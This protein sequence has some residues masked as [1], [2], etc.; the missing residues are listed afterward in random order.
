MNNEVSKQW[1]RREGY[2]GPESFPEDELAAYAVGRTDAL[3]GREHSLYL[4]DG[5]VLHY[6]FT[7][8]ETLTAE[9]VKGGHGFEARDCQYTATESA[10]GIF[11]LK[12]GYDTNERL[13]T[14]V[15]LD[16]NRNQAVVIDGEIPAE[17]DD[18]YRLR[19]THVGGC[20]GEPPAAGEI[21]APSFPPDLVGKRFVADYSE[22]YAWELIYMNETR[23][24]WQGLKGNPGIGDTE[25]YDASSFAPGVYTVSWSEE[26]ETLAAVFL[27]NF[28]ART[29][30]GHMW[31]YAPELK[32]FL[33]A[34]LGGRIVDPSEFG[35]RHTLPGDTDT[36]KAVKQKNVDVVLRAHNEVWNQGNYDLINEIYAEDY[37]CHFI[38]GLEAAGQ[39][40]VREFISAHRKSFP[41]WTE[42]V[43]DIIA[44][45]DRVVTRYISTGTHEGEFQ[46][47]AATGRKITISEVSI[48]RVLNGKIVE[49][50]GFPDGL[51]HIRQLTDD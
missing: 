15:I 33:H 47:I 7:D 45:G 10:P 19:K 36:A 31:G 26:A 21:P 41:D 22:R 28:D 42:K 20:I 50:W 30:T 34:P 43:V 23:V 12:H 51:S 2:G 49:Q 48:H 8:G 32:K 40:G 13:T 17:G 1:K 9:G 37:Q 4:T 24:A 44:D 27:Y 29:I 3:A 11:F 35:L 39:E 46:G 16:L 25:T 5:R 14:C 38:C 6:V 18:D